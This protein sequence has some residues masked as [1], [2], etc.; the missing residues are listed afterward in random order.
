MSLRPECPPPCSCFYVSRLSHLPT[1]FEPWGRPQ[2][3]TSMIKSQPPLLAANPC[4][5]THTSRQA[6]GQGQENTSPP[7]LESRFCRM[8]SAKT[9]LRRQHSTLTLSL[10][11]AY[12]RATTHCTTSQIGCATGLKNKEH[13]HMQTKQLASSECGELAISAPSDANPSAQSCVDTHRLKFNSHTLWMHT[14]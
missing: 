14:D 7:P 8:F 12:R 2:I 13:A 1:Y 4:G 6:W 11:H 10:P 5:T 3:E 9:F